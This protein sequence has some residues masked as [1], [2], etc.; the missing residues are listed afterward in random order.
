MLHEK[1]AG[2]ALDL[3]DRD[4]WRQNLSV[5]LVTQA[6]LL[7][8]AEKAITNMLQVLIEKSKLRV[9]VKGAPA[10]LDGD[11]YG[12]VKP[13]DSF[14]NSDGT[15]LEITLQKVTPS[16]LTLHISIITVLYPHGRTLRLIY[17]FG[18]PAYC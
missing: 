1:K 4:R 18:T 11:L 9:G 17:C 15:A 14:W 3:H 10:V 16:A 7:G 5:F 8:I 6:A 2:E 12:A 13:D